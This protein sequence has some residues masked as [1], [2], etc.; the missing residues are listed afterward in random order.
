MRKSP[1]DYLLICM[2]ADGC[3]E[4]PSAD[5]VNIQPLDIINSDYQQNCVNSKHEKGTNS[6]KSSLI[7]I[8]EKKILYKLHTVA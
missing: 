7:Q 2:E 6:K 1:N 4:R 3:Q 5:F 8:N